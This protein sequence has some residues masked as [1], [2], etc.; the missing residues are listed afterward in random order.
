M[1]QA[2][3]G[4]VGIVLSLPVGTNTFKAGTQEMA[5]LRFA[6]SSNATGSAQM[7]L[8]DHP[9]FR[10]V[11]DSLA[12]SPAQNH[13]FGRRQH[14]FLANVGH[15]WNSGGNWDAF[16]GCRVGGPQRHRNQCGRRRD[17]GN[18]ACGAGADV[19]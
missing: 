10:E 2:T 4:Q 3:N 1:S 13:T 16:V 11:S 18:G 6:V 15:E 12:N 14:T 5:V 8:G 7:T 9:A 19:L 17:P